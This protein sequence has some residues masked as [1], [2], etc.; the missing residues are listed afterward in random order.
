[1]TVEVG[2]SCFLWLLLLKGPKNPLRSTRG[3]AIRDV[4]SVSFGTTSYM[5]ADAAHIEGT[6][7]SIRMASKERIA[8]HPAPRIAIC[9]G[10]ESKTLVQC[11]LE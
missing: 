8:M 10:D 6:S 3:V 4:R 9:S 11:V 7:S 1:M 5:S 2:D